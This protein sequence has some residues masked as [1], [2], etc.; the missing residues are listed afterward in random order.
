MN[1]VTIVS[2]DDSKY[3]LQSQNIVISNI[4][5]GVILAACLV[6]FFVRDIRGAI[7]MAFSIPFSIIAAFSLLY[8]YGLSRNIL[9]LGGMALAAGM[10]LDGSIVILENIHK[11]I[12]YGKKVMWAAIDGTSEV[13]MGIV[14]SGLTTI[15]VFLP[16]LFTHGIIRE[17]FKDLA[18]AIIAAIIFST[19]IGIIFMPMMGARILRQKQKYEEMFIVKRLILKGLEKFDILLEMIL[20][21][22]LKIGIKTRPRRIFIVFILMS[23]AVGSILTLPS[24]DFIPKGKV[25]EIQVDLETPAGSTLEYT[26]SK[27]KEVEKILKS[28]RVDS[29]HD[30]FAVT[31][32]VT[33]EVHNQK[34]SVFVKIKFKRKVGVAIKDQRNIILR[35]L[36]FCSGIFVPSKE[37]KSLNYSRDEVF[38]VVEAIRNRLR[39]LAGAQDTKIY[40]NV[41]EKVN[42][43]GVIPL[44]VSIVPKNPKVWTQKKFDRI[45]KEEF[46][47]VLK[48]YRVLYILER[49]I[50]NRF[51]NLR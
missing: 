48:K 30:K 37:E 34:A 11:H 21:F 17:I 31:E 46:F 7:L 13:A 23:F 18:L 49:Q 44:K 39:K 12:E 51:L 45:S 27:A 2:R 1:F 15:L 47:Q 28:F 35:M 6:M 32:T 26:D 3:I 36:D 33:A 29:F 41:L 4:L 14:T 43:Q 38:M 42:P 8:A 40:V 25:R 20:E 24:K 50:A 16:L 9:T 19:V 10:V 5:Q 22:F